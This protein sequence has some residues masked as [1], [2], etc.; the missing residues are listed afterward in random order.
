[1]SALLN[2]CSILCYCTVL[3]CAELRDRYA[4][5]ADQPIEQVPHLPMPLHTL[6]RLIPTAYGTQES[7]IR[8][9]DMNLTDG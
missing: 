5:L 3:L 7:R 2:P 8:L 9:L 4:Y 1:V 6:I